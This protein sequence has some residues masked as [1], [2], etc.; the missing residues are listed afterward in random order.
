M[1]NQYIGMCRGPNQITDQHILIP[2]QLPFCY[3]SLVWFE[4]EIRE[5]RTAISEAD[6]ENSFRNKHGQM[7]GR[8][9]EMWKK[10]FFNSFVG[11]REGFHGSNLELPAQL[12]LNLTL[13]G[14]FNAEQRI[15]PALLVGSGLLWDDD[16]RFP[17]CESL[18]WQFTP[19]IFHRIG[20]RNQSQAIFTTDLEK[21]FLNC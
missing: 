8:V 18:Y 12:K 19:T 1:S 13:W 20:L 5:Y 7:V 14:I 2:A 10:P 9:Q 15:Q 3:L 21:L 6:P 16:V 17:L 4:K 11:E